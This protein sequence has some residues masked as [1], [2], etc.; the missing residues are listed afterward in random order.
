VFSHGLPV[1]YEIDNKLGIKSPEDVAKIGIAAYNAECRA[2]VMR[3]ASEWESVRRD[4]NIAPVDNII[5]HSFL[6]L[7]Q[8]VGRMGRWIDFKNDYKT[9]DPTFMETVWWVFK[10][11]WDKD[12][13]F[14]GFKVMPFS[15]ACNTP[16]S[17]F[18]AQQNYKDVRDPAVVVS[19][20]VVGDEETSFL[21][22]TTTPWTLPSN[23]ALCVNPALDYVKV[24]DK[25]TNRKY[26]MGESRVVQ[27]Y[28]KKKGEEYDVLE[29]VK[30]AQLEGKRYLPLFPYFASTPGSDQYFR[31]VSD[32]YVTDSDGTGIVHQA[33][34]FGEEDFRVCQKHGVIRPGGVGVPCPVDDSGRFTAEVPEFQGKHVKEADREIISTL[35]GMSRLIQDGNIDHPYPHCWRSDTPLIYR[36]VP[37]WFVNVPAI[38]DRLIGNNKQTRWVPSFVGESRF[39]NWLENAREWAISR[40]RYWGTPLPI[41]VSADGKEIKVIG[42]VQELRDASGDQTITDIHRDKI[43]DI[44][45]PSA[46]GAEF[47]VL[48]RVPE[49]FDC[50]FES[51]SMPYAQLHY[52]FEN[53][54]A[55]ENGFP[56]D[57]IAEGLD[58]TRGWFY[59]LMVISTALFDKPAFKNLIVNGLVL[60]S[61]GKKMSKRLKNYPDPMEVVNQ[62]GA[63]AN[64]CASRPRA[65]ATWPAMSFC[66]G[67]TPT[68]SSSCRR[69]A[70]SCRPVLR[71]CR[72]TL[73]PCTRPL[74]M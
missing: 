66:R 1:E 9:L 3:Y 73:P 21:A 6:V 19:F 7:F 43:D 24:L 12:L 58:Q 67:S 57:F 61:D 39:H 70:C 62:C 14:K 37:S 31:V 74:T 8:I 44:V 34:A 51:G 16:L 55:F 53:K 47:G 23:L 11:M 72:L 71:L 30:G 48:R 60:A 64:L 59:T 42:S 26:W 65:C 50:W 20:P 15:T 25:K 10:Q 38:K 5:D 17:N 4:S 69:V 29:K 36:A 46:R 56:A 18:E 22:W 33:P 27:I 13:V 28:K 40:N 49:V 54:E 45:I 52:P 35:R 2:I 32:A 63:D 41:W 68:A